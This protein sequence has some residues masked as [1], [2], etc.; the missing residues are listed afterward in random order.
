[1]ELIRAGP[2]TLDEDA[3]RVRGDIEPPML[4]EVAFNSGGLEP[5]YAAASWGPQE[6]GG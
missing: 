1:M 5:D 4:G 2:V 3:Q 6:E